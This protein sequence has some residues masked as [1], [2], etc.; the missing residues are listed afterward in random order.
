MQRYDVVSVQGYSWGVSRHPDSVWGYLR[1][2]RAAMCPTMGG[3]WRVF[4]KTVNR[5]RTD[6][7]LIV[8]CD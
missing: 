5:W 4:D 6:Q 7:S 2:S 8:A 1:S 3:Q